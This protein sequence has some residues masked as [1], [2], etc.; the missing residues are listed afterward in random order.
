MSLK[1]ALAVT[2]ALAAP[3]ALAAGDS[4]QDHI[5]AALAQEGYTSIRVSRTLLGRLR[6]IAEKSGARREIVV[7]PVTGLIMRDYVQRLGQDDD[8]DRGGS[9]GS[10]D[11]RDDDDDDDDDP[12]DDDDKDDDD[13]DR[14]NSGSGS[15]SSGKGKSGS[16]G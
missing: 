4:V 10:D 9:S 8:D 13:D 14:D 3:H 5:V 6:I 11:D 12:D 16:G 15:S 7:H 2:L 1:F